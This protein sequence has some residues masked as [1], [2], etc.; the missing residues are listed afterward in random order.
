MSRHYATATAVLDRTASRPVVV[1]DDLSRLRGPSTGIVAL[2]VGLDWT[3]RAGYDLSRPAA[4]RS[5]Y[6]V[7]LR[8]ARTEAD[9]ETYLHADVLASV[10]GTLTLPAPVRQFWEAA[11]PSLTH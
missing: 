4:A 7:V 10:W 2:P 3:P 6:Q 8:E 11:H 9:I 1:V 5:L